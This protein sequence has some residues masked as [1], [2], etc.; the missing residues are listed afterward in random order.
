LQKEHGDSLQD[1]FDKLFKE[2]GKDM[3]K[4][5]EDSSW[6]ANKDEFDSLMH[7]KINIL[8]DLPPED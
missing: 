8:H 4:G 6:C 5:K 3:D 1:K 7:Q 2:Y